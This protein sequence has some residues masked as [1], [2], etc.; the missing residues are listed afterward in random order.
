MRFCRNYVDNEEA[1]KPAV[2]FE[3]EKSC[4]EH[5]SKNINPTSSN[6]QFPAHHSERADNRGQIKGGGIKSVGTENDNYCSYNSG[7]PP[8]CEGNR[9]DKSSELLNSCIQSSETEPLVNVTST[10][11]GSTHPV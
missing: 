7:S 11:N 10:G 6:A 8:R 9:D 2:K 3:S 5:V 1:P 4:G